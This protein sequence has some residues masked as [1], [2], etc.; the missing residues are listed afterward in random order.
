MIKLHS[1]WPEFEID[2]SQHHHILQ[3]FKAIVTKDDVGFFRFIQHKEHSGEAERIAKD[4]QT[5][6]LLVHVGIGGS[7]LGPEML[8]SALGIKTGKRVQFVNNID[9]DMLHR[10]MKEWNVADTFFYIVSKSGGTPETL[11][12][13]SLITQWLTDHKI[14]SKDWQ[15]YI[16]LCTD[17]HKGDLRLMAKKYSLECLDVPTSIGG[18]FSVMTDVGFLT[19]AWAG[20]D[21]E[22]IRQGA[23]AMCEDILNMNADQ[24]ILTQMTQWLFH[25]YQTGRSQTVLM[26]Y[27]SLLKDFSAWWVQLWAESLGKDLKGLTPIMSYGATDQHSQMQL[28]MQGPQDK[29]IIMLEVESSQNTLPMKADL[30][31]A[32][33]N[34][35]KGFTLHDLMKAEFTGTL[36]ALEG[37]KRPYIHLGL[38]ALTPEALGQLILLF[39]CLT[40]TVGLCIGVDPFNQPGVEAGKNFARDWL[41]KHKK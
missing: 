24:N 11:A 25:H 27:S 31:L 12:A 5:K 39:Q 7:S 26:P 13:L 6:K 15:Q 23:F 17:P 2:E 33:T 21:I 14:Q 8:V 4:F 30:D 32:G 20:I 37:E 18:R 40:L 16:V 35:L 10:Q 9:S 1:L 19:A 41:I 34:Q 38:P 3:Q 29:T 28:F 22:K 36:Q